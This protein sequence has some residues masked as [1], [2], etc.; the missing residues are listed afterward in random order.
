MEN[1][2]IR[3]SNLWPVVAGLLLLLNLLWIALH[4]PFRFF[5]GANL[6]AVY[7][8]ILISLTVLPFPL[9]VFEDPLP[10][11]ILGPLRV[12]LYP[13]GIGRLGNLTPHLNRVDLLNIAAFIPFGFLLPFTTRNGKLPILLVGFLATLAIEA[14]QLILT[15]RVATYSRAFDINDLI[16]N[17]TGALLGYLLSRPLFTRERTAL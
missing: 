6:F 9:S 13:F 10:E 7:L 11:A 2:V 8:V 14:T 1:I 4:K 3:P 12:N 16:T 17:V 5:L 15:S